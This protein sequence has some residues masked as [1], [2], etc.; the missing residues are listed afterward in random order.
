MI[1]TKK[2]HLIWMVFF[3]FFMIINYPIF[4]IAMSKSENI[5]FPLVK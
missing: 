1:H 5:F 3:V 2:N 4:F